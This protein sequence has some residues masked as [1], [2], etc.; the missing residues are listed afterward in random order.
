MSSGSV[1][2]D[3]GRTF[4]LLPG[5][6]DIKVKGPDDQVVEKKSINIQSGQTANLDIQ[7]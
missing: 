7:F 6:Y 3:K 4:D 2:E 1:K 5:V